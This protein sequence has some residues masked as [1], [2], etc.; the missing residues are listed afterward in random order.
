L[1]EVLADPKWSMKMIKAYRFMHEL[2][3]RRDQGDENTEKP[4]DDAAS[5]VPFY[6]QRVK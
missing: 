3:K 4:D 2:E 6:S 5:T 1:Q